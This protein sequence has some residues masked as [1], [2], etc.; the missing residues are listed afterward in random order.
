MHTARRG[1]VSIWPLITAL[2]LVG[3]AHR[4]TREGR[5]AAE[6]ADDTR[7]EA[8]AT[9]RDDRSRDGV[10]P[11]DAARNGRQ[12][13]AGDPTLAGRPQHSSPPL[14]PELEAFRTRLLNADDAQMRQLDASYYQ[15][16]AALRQAASDPKK[17]NHP[18]DSLHSSDVDVR[19]NAMCELA[20]RRSPGALESLSRALRDDADPFNRTIAVWCLRS[21]GSQPAVPAALSDFL[22]GCRD[23]DLGRYLA[24]DGT[25]REFQSPFPLAGF[26]AF[27]ALLAMRGK[28]EMLDG[29][30]WRRFVVRC[31]KRIQPEP[32]TAIDESQRR[33]ST[34]PRT[35]PYERARQWIDEM[36]QP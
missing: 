27:K 17:D 15:F 2:L 6:S 16:A 35:D 21:L 19:A 34:A 13:S 31:G 22:D 7:R 30:G 24:D 14:T 8:A 26:E 23:I 28:A 3:C 29:D 18:A 10:R 11:D 33:G 12:G 20:A 1:R 36:R 9:V 5:A 25:T 32:I 4:T